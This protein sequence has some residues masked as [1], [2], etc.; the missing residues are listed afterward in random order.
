MLCNSQN[1]LGSDRHGFIHFPGFLS[2]RTPPA[3][4]PSYQ[5]AKSPWPARLAA[6]SSLTWCSLMSTD[7]DSTPD[8]IFD[9]LLFSVIF[10]HSYT[11]RDAGDAT[12]CSLLS[13]GRAWSS[14]GQEPGSAGS[15]LCH[16]FQFRLRALRLGDCFCPCSV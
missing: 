3:A 9:P 12:R 6:G 1:L 11:L 4:F 16:V 15:Q 8:H 5:A 10:L 7:I 13:I 2:L 14:I